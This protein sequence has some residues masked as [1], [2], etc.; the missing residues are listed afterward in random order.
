MGTQL[1][2]DVQQTLLLAGTVG[3]LPVEAEAFEAYGAIDI[4]GGFRWG[5]QYLHLGLLFK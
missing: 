4:G 3:A 5:A 1:V 2:V